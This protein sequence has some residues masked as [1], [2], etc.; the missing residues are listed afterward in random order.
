MKKILFRKLLWDCSKFF[1][2]SL[3]SASI[4][5][6]I[7]QAVNFLDIIV[8]DGR[9]FKVYLTYTIL[10]LPKII[11]KI[12]PFALFFSIFYIIN[13]YEKNNEL[14]IF[15]NFG[16][17]KIDLVN[18]FFKISLIFTLIQITLTV[19]FVPLSQNIS[20]NLIKDSNIG[21]FESLIKPKKFNDN[22]RGLT[23]YADD[24]DKN[25]KLK[26]IYLKKDND[27]RNYQITVAKTGEFISSNN[28]KILKLYNGQTVNLL[29]N[30]MTT[31][32]FSKSDFILN[33]L[34]SD[35]IIQE[36]VQE[37]STLKHFKCIDKYFNKNLTLK[38][39]PGQFVN[40]NCSLSNLNNIFQELYKRFIL[41]LY[42]PTL[43][44]IGLLT[45]IK[46]KEN[47][48]F[49]RY[50]IMVFLIGIIVIIISE[51]SVKFIVDNIFDNLKLSTIPIILIFCIYIYYRYQFDFKIKKI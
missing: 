32:N 4:I 33:S 40:A 21:F 3:I 17:P 25:G 42:L 28:S 27:D 38:K 19:V 47:I 45:V 23:I 48:F 13:D 43:I 51:S 22:V 6:W 46:S 30:K 35:I 37:T 12:L 41:P 34:D 29:N 31:F 24:K 5:I 10:Q 50:K 20:R 15:W 9:D 39:E 26:N 18:F 44:L 16:I 11:S 36:K 1:L 7:F 14:I 2:I 8:E 49:Q